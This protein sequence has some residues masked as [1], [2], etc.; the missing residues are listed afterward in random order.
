I[1]LPSLNPW[2]P[3]TDVLS[4]SKF[5]SPILNTVNIGDTR[6]FPIEDGAIYDFST[7]KDVRKIV[8]RRR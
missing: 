7:V 2:A 5:L 8:T 6:V 3:G 1:V 4:T